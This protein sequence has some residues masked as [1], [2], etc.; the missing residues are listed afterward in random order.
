[1]VKHNGVYYL[2][3]SGGGWRAAYGMGYATSSTPTG[4]FTKAPAPILAETADVK[5]PGGGDTPVVG[6]NGGVWIPYHGRSAS[7][8]EPRVLRLDRFSWA[9]GNGGP[10]VPVIAGPTSTPQPDKP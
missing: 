4:P 1:M 9:S 2:L 8:S 3:Y 7:R 10:D 6:P 5:S